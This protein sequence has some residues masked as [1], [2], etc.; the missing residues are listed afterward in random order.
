MVARK[1]SQAAPR[2]STA[3]RRAKAQPSTDEDARIERE[4]REAGATSTLQSASRRASELAKRERLP[5]GGKAKSTRVS[6]P[7]RST[8]DQ[9]SKRPGARGVDGRAAHG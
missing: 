1:K 6:N 3:K 7:K 8:A 9:A 2:K 4:V 5:R